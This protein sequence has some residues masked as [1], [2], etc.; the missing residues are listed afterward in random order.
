MNKTINTGTYF[1]ETWPL[2][3]NAIVCSWAGYRPESNSNV[4]LQVLPAHIL[5]TLQ[6]KH[7]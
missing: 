4:G 1:P 3:E 5:A 7:R 2:K 6:T